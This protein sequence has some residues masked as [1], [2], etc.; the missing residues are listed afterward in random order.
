MMR[1][2]LQYLNRYAVTIYADYPLLVMFKVSEIFLRDLMNHET[3][4]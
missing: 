1:L 3:T 4:E 2:F